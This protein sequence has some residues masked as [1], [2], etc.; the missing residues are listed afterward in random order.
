MQN[1]NVSLV[2]ELREEI[3]SMLV[4]GALSVECKDLEDKTCR[5]ERGHMMEINLFFALERSEK[6]NVGVD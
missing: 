5:L 4:R 6:S 3:T 2:A 1:A